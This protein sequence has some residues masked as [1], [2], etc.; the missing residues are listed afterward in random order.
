VLRATVP[1][2][3]RT[4]TAAEPRVATQDY[5]GCEPMALRLPS[6]PRLVVLVTGRL[7][8][9]SAIGARLRSITA[10]RGEHCTDMPPEG[11]PIA[12]VTFVTDALTARFVIDRIREH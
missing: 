6:T 1:P 11:L 7:P 3:A 12:I 9:T 5:S 8:V 2:P 4:V 10:V